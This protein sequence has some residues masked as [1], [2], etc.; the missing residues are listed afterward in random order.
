MLFS[1]Y[2]DRVVISSPSFPMKYWD[3]F[4]RRKAR[5]KYADQCDEESLMALLGQEK[6]AGDAVD[7]R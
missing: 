1:S 5:Q 7:F 6:A 4:V 2:L 3:K